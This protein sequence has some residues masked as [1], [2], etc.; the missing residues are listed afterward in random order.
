MAGLKEIDFAAIESSFAS[1]IR[2][3]GRFKIGHVLSPFVGVIL[4][5][6]NPVL[7]HLAVT[8]AGVITCLLFYAAAR[9]AGADKTS[10]LLFVLLFAVTGGQNSVWYRLLTGETWGM[11]LAAIA[12][13]A[14]VKAARRATPSFWD[15]VAILAMV[16]MATFKESFILLIPAM[17]LLRWAMQR[18][19]NEQSW[20]QS[21]LALHRPLIAGGIIFSLFLLTTIGILRYIP[22]GYGA[23]VAGLSARSFDP[24]AWFDLLVNS[25]MAPLTYGLPLFVILLLVIYRHRHLAYQHLLSVVMVIIAWVIPQLILHGSGIAGHYQFPAV[26]GLAGLWGLTLSLL[27]REQQRILWTAG[28]IWA[29][30]LILINVN[31]TIENSSYYTADT[32]ALQDMIYHLAENVGPEQSI[33]IIADPNVQFEGAISLRTHLHSAGLS[34]GV[35]LLPVFPAETETEGALATELLNIH[36]AGFTDLESLHPTEVGAIIGLK[37]PTPTT[38]IPSWYIPTTWQEE[39]FSHPYYNFSLAQFRYVKTG[40]VGYTI[41]L[42]TT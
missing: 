36:F 27:W 37:A 9:Q 24:G 6:T 1:N 3:G 29:V 4:F 2:E 35:Y 42:P 18:W 15:G 14:I 23:R 12:V 26:V 7:W 8:S 39:T 40:A 22:D 5:G 16:L 25:D 32:L 17:L 11:L 20:R 41:L 19:F 33:I 38:P 31:P 30:G 28:A 34:S 13:W 10:S 21:L